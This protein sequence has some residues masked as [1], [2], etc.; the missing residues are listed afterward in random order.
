MS[1]SNWPYLKKND[2]VDIISTTPGINKSSLEN[3]LIF[4]SG[5]V[6]QMGLMPR[7]N[8]E[9]MLKGA[10][11]FSN[12]SLECRK[13]ELVKALMA[14]DSKAIWVIRGG[15]GT[16]KLLTDLKDITAP[17]QSK[18]L[19]GYSDI[20]CL[21]LWL[22]KFWHWPSLHA[23]V[24][25]EYLEEQ[26]A[27]DLKLLQDIIFG[28]TKQVVFKNLIPLNQLAT[29][30]SSI[31][32]KVTGGTVQVLQSGIGLEWQV[33]PKDKILFFEEIF[34]RGV[35]LE[36][37]LHHF[38]QLGL[39]DKTKA[40]LFGDIICGKEID[41]SETC[42]TAIKYFAKNITIPVFKVQ[43]IGHGRFNHPF[44]LNTDSEIVIKNGKAKL[45][46]SVMHGL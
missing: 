44:P 14:E 9:S 25:Y 32:G 36:R 39:L 38:Q 3:D 23:R 16:A 40:I 4:L 20:N 22:H 28:N 2:I 30:N 27:K 37:S 19:I 6:K 21:H 42:D 46:C 31:K 43:G 17:K 26:D 1:Y 24:L 18:L 35:R 8:F 45:I 15:Y 5:F 29:I 10:D 13:Q 11:F 34:D 12:E 7:I 41:G 33:D